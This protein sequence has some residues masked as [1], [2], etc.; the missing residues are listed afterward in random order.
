[1]VKKELLK[2][3]RYGYLAA[4]SVVHVTLH[5]QVPCW[6]K[7]KKKVGRERRRGPVTL[8]HAHVWKPQSW[9]CY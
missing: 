3:G 4:Q 7:K 9:K 1:M 6:V 8:V 2:D 5:L